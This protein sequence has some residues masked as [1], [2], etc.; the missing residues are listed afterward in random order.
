MKTKHNL[1]MIAL[2]F[3]LFG[4]I[5]IFAGEVNQKI[6]VSKPSNLAGVVVALEALGPIKQKYQRRKET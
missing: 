1:M 6:Q 5:F 4:A 3:F 2:I